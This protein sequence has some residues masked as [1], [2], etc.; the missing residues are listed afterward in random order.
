MSAPRAARQRHAVHQCRRRHRRQLPRVEP[1]RPRIDRLPTRRATPP[2]TPSPLPAKAAPR[3]APRQHQPG[4]DGAALRLHPFRAGQRRRSRSTTRACSLPRRSPSISRR[5]IA[6]R[7]QCGDPPG[8]AARSACPRTSTAPSRAR[9][10]LFQQSLANE[11]LLIARG[12]ASPST[13]C[14]ASST[15]AT[16][17]RSRSSRPCPRPASARCWR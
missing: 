16:S 14:S 17:T 1:S 4:D 8:D 9:R 10:R 15:R 5:A 7:R 12:A 2:S 6:E 11:P 3:P 13:S